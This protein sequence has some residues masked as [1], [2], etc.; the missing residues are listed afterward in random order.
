MAFS[1]RE[2]ADIHYIYGLCDGNALAAQRQ[3]HIRFPG[4]IV[5]SSQVFSRVHQ[6]I[7]ES[8]S[9]KKQRNEVGPAQNI[10]VEEQILDRVNENPRLSSRQLATEIG[11]SHT[12]ILK[13]L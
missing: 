2:Y 5:P 8:G 4:R 3:Y 11:T 6:R 12:K 1:N 7:M 9:V 10:A 13:V